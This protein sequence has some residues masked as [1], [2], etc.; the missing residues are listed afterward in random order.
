MIVQACQFVFD[1][2]NEYLE[3]NY[4]VL[5]LEGADAV[6]VKLISIKAYRDMK[7]KEEE[8]NI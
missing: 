2:F 1:S 5:H 3:N 8:E 6:K 4:I 7:L